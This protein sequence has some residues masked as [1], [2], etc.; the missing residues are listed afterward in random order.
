MDLPGEKNIQKIQYGSRE[1]V[2]IV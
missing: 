2:V 1:A